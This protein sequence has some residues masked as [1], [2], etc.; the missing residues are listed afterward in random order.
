MN[1]LSYLKKRC[2]N[3]VIM[4]ECK[5]KDR[6]Y[7]FNYKYP[8]KIR[9]ALYGGQTLATVLY[10][11]CFHAGKIFHVD[12]NS[13]YLVQYKKLYPVGHPS[14]LIDNEKIQAFLQNEIEKEENI[15]KTGFLKCKVLPP[16]NS[17]FPVLPTCV[18]KKLLFVLCNKCAILKDHTKKCDH[19]EHE[20]SI[21]GTWCLHEIYEAVEQNYK[22][23]ESDELL[24]YG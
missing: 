19:S 9:D 14:V 21:K 24:Y 16:Q 11:D 17:L 6:N 23:F 2:H 4:K 20:R 7:Y 18:N 5:Y 12:F 1:R 3:L 22:I 15:R 13:L 8:L 10:K